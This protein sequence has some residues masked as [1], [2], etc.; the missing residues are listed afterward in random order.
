MW[1]T[2][3]GSVS[4][5]CLCLA[6]DSWLG[7]RVS[8]DIQGLCT[9]GPKSSVPPLHAQGSLA[10]V[11]GWFLGLGAAPV[12]TQEA[13]AVRSPGTSVTITKMRRIKL[14]IQMKWQKCWLLRF[15]SYRQF[16]CLLKNKQTCTHFFFSQQTNGQYDKHLQEGIPACHTKGSVT[17]SGPQFPHLSS[18][19]WGVNGMIS[20]SPFQSPNA[21]I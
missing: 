2:E 7:S 10:K 15:L 8:K 6:P 13:F 9:K 19:G 16:H 18:W 5:P 21:T 3:W 1:A 12:F 4:Q 11:T 14:A 20:A 17:L